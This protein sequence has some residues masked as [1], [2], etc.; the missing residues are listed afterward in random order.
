MVVGLKGII[1]FGKPLLQNQNLGRNI[2][3]VCNT[4]YPE[5]SYNFFYWLGFFHKRLFSMN[6]ILFDERSFSNG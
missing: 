4:F 3:V 2:K 5:R 6:Y 1:G